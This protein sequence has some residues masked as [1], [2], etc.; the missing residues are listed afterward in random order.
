MI[1]NFLHKGALFRKDITG[2]QKYLTKYQV[3]LWT[4]C[5]PLPPFAT[6]SSCGRVGIRAPVLIV[7][8]TL[9]MI[10]QY[11]WLLMSGNQDSCGDL[12]RMCIQGD[13]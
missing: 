8:C 5:P 9:N 1:T 13:K 6:Q 10:S 11:L 12:D 7:H 2:N 3:L 4:L